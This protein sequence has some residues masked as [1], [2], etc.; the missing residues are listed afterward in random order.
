LS[1]DNA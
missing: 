1:L